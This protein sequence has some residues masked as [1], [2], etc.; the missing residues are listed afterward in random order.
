MNHYY[1]IV[2]LQGDE[3]EEALEIYNRDD[4]E[5]FKY[6]E[7]WDNGEYPEHLTFQPW[8]SGS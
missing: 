5:L 6:L 1:P 7:Q 4:Q 3:A 2:F 8:G